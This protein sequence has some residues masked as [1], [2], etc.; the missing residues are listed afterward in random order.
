MPER[1]LIVVVTGWNI[2]DKPAVAARL[3]E[4]DAADR[5]DA[6]ALRY[7]RAPRAHASLFGGNAMSLGMRTV[8]GRGLGWIAVAL[9]AAGFAGAELALASAQAPEPAAKVQYLRA[10]A[11]GAKAR[12]LQDAGALVACDATG[13]LSF[14]LLVAACGTRVDDATFERI[15]A[16]L[17]VLDSDGTPVVTGPGEP[18]GGSGEA[19]GPPGTAPVT[20]PGTPTTADRQA[21]TQTPTTD[22]Q[23]VTQ[24]PGPEVPGPETPG[25]ETPGPEGPD[26]GDPGDP[27]PG[28]QNFASDVGIT[29]TGIRIGT[30][31]S[32]DGPLGPRQFSPTYFGANAYFAWRNSQGGINGR[33]V[34]YL[35]CDDRESEEAAQSE[36]VRLNGR[37]A[38]T[39]CLGDR[40]DDRQPGNPARGN[41]LLRA[42][43]LPAASRPNR[44]GANGGSIGSGIRFGETERAE[45]PSGNQIGKKACFLLFRAILQN[46]GDDQERNVGPPEPPPRDLAA[47]LP[48]EHDRRALALLHIANSNAVGIEELV[49]DRGSRRLR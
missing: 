45:H 27:G 44:A 10:G 5:Y 4:R 19:A 37:P 28:E 31:V 49:R 34:E 17:V 42:G 30:V 9:L 43:Q 20:L 33:Q 22:G 47:G 48:L 18:A 1:G 40:E 29:E 35:H 13:T 41:E 32:I 8:G 24:A 23:P 15:A 21:V 11:Q 46:R 25:P 3:V 38:G 2:Y 36:D 16:G 6:A 39:V 12:N 14:A 7:K 26:P